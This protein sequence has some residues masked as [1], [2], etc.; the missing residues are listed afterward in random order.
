MALL[1]LRLT[2]ATNLGSGEVLAV[3]QL[4]ANF[5]EGVG[6]NFSSHHYRSHGFAVQGGHDFGNLLRGFAYAKNYFGDTRAQR[7]V[8]IHKGKVPHCLVGYVFD[9]VVGYLR[10]NGSTGDPLQ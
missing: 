9:V 4:L 8:V 6:G 3:G 2:Q 10:T 1:R 5:C 7:A